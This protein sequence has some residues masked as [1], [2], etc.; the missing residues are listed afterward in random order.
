MPNLHL[1]VI[2]SDLGDGDFGGGCPAGAGDGGALQNAP[3]I[4]GCAPPTANSESPNGRFIED[5]D[6]GGGV[7]LANYPSGQLADAFSC[8]AKLG[9]TGCGFQQPL[10]SI[11]RALDGSNP[12]N[13]GFLRADATLAIVI[14]SDGDDCSAHDN[15]IFD[16]NP[17]LDTLLGPYTGFRC[18]EFGVMCDGADLTRSA[19]TYTTCVPRGDSYL[20]DPQHYVD[21]LGA[22]KSDPADVFVS[23]ITGPSSPFSVSLDSSGDPEV[24]ASC[25]DGSSS[26][27]PAVRDEAFATSFG[28]H[29][30]ETTICQSEFGDSLTAL[31]R[32]LVETAGSLCLEGTIDTTDQDAP[33]PGLQ[34]GCTASD[35]VG[36]VATAIPACPMQDPT[37]PEGSPRPCWWTTIDTTVCSASLF[38]SS[39]LIHV[40]GVLPDPSRLVVTCP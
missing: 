13:A 28:N 30:S 21:F 17:G 8:I 3:K 14:V 27:T 23:T 25:T 2:S 15:M 35:V 9:N 19:A 39:A 26:A 31:G 12:A 32:A 20:W 38:P 29:G 24:D 18:E 1:G 34:L 4:A 7:R 22:V 10:E 16:P 11:K 33:T 6:T 5:I 40:E 36:G 37:T